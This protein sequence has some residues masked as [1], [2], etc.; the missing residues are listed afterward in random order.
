MVYAPLFLRQAIHERRQNKEFART[1][2]RAHV[3]LADGR[4]ACRWE[5][6]LPC[7][8]EGGQ[9]TF[10]THYGY[11]TAWAAR[12]LARLKPSKHVDISSCLRF[13]SLVS[14]F[15]PIEFYDYRPA[16]LS[17]SGLTMDHADITAL[18]FEG[19]SVE[20]LSSMHVVEH[21]GLG[22]Y[23]DSLDPQ[24]DVK[25]MSELS[26]VLAPDGSLLF[27]VPV[28]KE[29][30]IQFNAHRIYTPELVRKGFPALRLVEFSYI[31]DP[32][33]WPE[34]FIQIASEKDIDND[35]YGCGCFHFIKE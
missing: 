27:V 1:F 28:G 12:V 9:Y 19:G 4:F 18:P 17:L 25:A 14:A 8:N 13:V 5:D 29:P 3:T 31:S 30:L 15:I 24:G 35:T 11:H 33:A 2:Q 34:R 20:S 26:R 32:A 6:R 7:F 10:S 16:E 22:R 23:G 21:V